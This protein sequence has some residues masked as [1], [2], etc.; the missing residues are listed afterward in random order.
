MRFCRIGSLCFH[1]LA[2]SAFSLVIFPAPCCCLVQPKTVSFVLM[3]GE[4]RDGDKV[5]KA[6]HLSPLERSVMDLSEAL[7]RVQAE[8]VCT[9]FLQT[10]RYLELPA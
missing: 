5:A 1:P 3:L 6:E 2:F 9:R 7:A 4:E 10:Y 8:Q